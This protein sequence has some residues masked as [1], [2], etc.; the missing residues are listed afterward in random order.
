MIIGLHHLTTVKE[1]A[2]G[3]GRAFRSISE[4]IL[5]KDQGSLRPQRQ[6]RSIRLENDYVPSRMRPTRGFERDHRLVETTLGRALFNETLPADYP[7]VRGRSPTR[8]S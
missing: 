5:A 1:G 2:V 4:A 7:Y 8:A 3:E 6:G